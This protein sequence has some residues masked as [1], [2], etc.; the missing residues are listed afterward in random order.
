MSYICTQLNTLQPSITMDI[1]ETLNTLKEDYDLR[2]SLRRKK[3]FVHE[4]LE[5]EISV[6]E[7]SYITTCI[8]PKM[9]AYAKDLLKDLE[10]DIC[11]TVVKELNGVIS[12]DSNE[13]IPVTDHADT[14]ESL[15][16]DPEEVFMVVPKKE[17]ETPILITLNNLIDSVGRN[18]RITID[19]KV[20]QEKN[21][22]QTFIAALK[23]LGLDR[24]AQV[25]IMCS[26]YNLVDTRQRTDGTRKWQQEE[27]GKWIYIYFSNPTKVR[28]L[29]QI[30][31]YLKE[32]IRIEA[33]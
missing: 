26:G 32:T 17:A 1:R 11:L 7:E 10:C 12:V 22:I 4:E 3:L 27:D 28:Y 15:G 19:G 16:I 24:I 31:E 25:G 14:V 9:E 2:N 30:A 33:V 8:I 5:D 6:L 13:S 29:F 18:L 23:H 21:S 20:Y